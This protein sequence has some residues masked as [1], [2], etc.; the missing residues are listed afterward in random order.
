M[1]L[2]VGLVG[3]ALGQ[4]LDPLVVGDV[5]DWLANGLGGEG[6]SGLLGQNPPVIV[7]D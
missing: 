6:V 2:E 3:E 1:V 4:F 5:V 7:L